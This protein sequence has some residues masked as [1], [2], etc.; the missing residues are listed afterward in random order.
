L[1]LIFFFLVNHFRFVRQSVYA[2]SRSASGQATDTGGE[3]VARSGLR[4]DVRV[5]AAR[6]AAAREPAGQHGLRG[7]PRRP[8]AGGRLGHAHERQDGLAR[9]VHAARHGLGP[10]R[11]ERRHRQD[12]PQH[13]ASPEAAVRLAAD[14]AEHGRRD[15]LV[16]IQQEGVHHSRELGERDRRRERRDDGPRRGLVQKQLVRHLLQ[17]ERARSLHISNQ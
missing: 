16:P 9:P 17:A 8:G 6:S 13:A 3:A 1:L 4:S 10:D 2:V 7:E 5:R 14:P 11:E 12:R 15:R